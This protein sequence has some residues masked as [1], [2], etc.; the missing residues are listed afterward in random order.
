MWSSQAVQNHRLN[1]LTF[2]GTF[3]NKVSFST[4]VAEKIECKPKA[5]GSHCATTWVRM[6][7]TCGRAEPR[8]KETD[9][10]YDFA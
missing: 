8:A 4:G 9:L 6:R 5:P 7:P 3:G 1:S 10:S 2:V